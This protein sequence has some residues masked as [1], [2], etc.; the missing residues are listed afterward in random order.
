MAL[1]KNRGR[2]PEKGE[3]VV[4][5]GAGRSGR[6]AAALLAREGA[7][8]RLLELNP[9][10]VTPERRRELEAKGI[11]VI[12]GPHESGQFA[13]AG[14]VVPSPGMPIAELVKLLDAAGSKPEIL[15]ELELAWRYLES[16]PVLA[17]TGTSG[18]T[19]TAS[20]AAA[21]LKTQGYAVFLG[22]NI[23]T[24]LSEYVLSGRKAD[25]LVLECSS[26][27]LQGCSTFCPRVAILLN[28]S[29]NHLDYHK[30]MAEYADAKFRI[31][32]CQDE[33]DLAI[34]GPGLEEAA[35]RFSIPG[36]RINVRA[37]DTFPKSQLLGAHNRLNEEAAWQACRFFGV[38]LENARS[39]VANFAPL[40]HRLE[41]IGD[42][43]GVTYVNDSKCTTVAAL[44]VALEAF[45]RPVR[46]LAGGKFKGGDLAAL[47]PLVKEKVA[48]V[49]LF[50]G[51]R[52]NFEKAWGGVVPISWHENLRQAMARLKGS[53]CIGDVILLAPA[54][55]SYDQYRDYI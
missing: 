11:E 7:R 40:P 35:A 37:G 30:D 48:E 39:A 25:V 32:R 38:S 51:S 15:S 36:R 23:G 21:M 9:E 49:A 27:Q 33:G 16:E 54:T 29:P 42:V 28:L 20:L 53:A 10:A 18:K 5:V 34:L 24:P 2:K 52:E 44:K 12:T 13:G 47:A 46:L 8:T 45:T 31:F 55:A 41:K 6:A 26:F 4:V 50:G 3:L 1:E 17:V 22:G 19:T 43:R 14:M